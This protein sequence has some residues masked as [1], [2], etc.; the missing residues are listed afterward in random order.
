MVR[1]VRKD[2]SES[3]SESEDDETYVDTKYVFGA[4]DKDS[5]DFN[6]TGVGHQAMPSLP[7]RAKSTHIY[8]EPSEVQNCSSNS[9]SQIK[10][11]YTDQFLRSDQSKVSQ[12]FAKKVQTYLEQG[13]VTDA[14]E[15]STDESKLSASHLR[16]LK[17][18]ILAE[19]GPLQGQLTELMH[20][21]QFLKDVLA[22]PGAEPRKNVSRV[23]S[24]SSFNTLVALLSKAKQDMCTL[25]MQAVNSYNTMM[26]YGN[27]DPLAIKRPVPALPDIPIAVF[28]VRSG[29]KAILGGPVSLSVKVDVKKGVL[30][31]VKEGSQA[32]DQANT[33]PADKIAQVIKSTRNSRMLEI[34]IE[35]RRK[36]TFMF[37]DIRQRE[38]FCQLVQQL[39]KVHSM[40]MLV[41]NLSVF[42]GTWNMGNELPPQLGGLQPWIKSQ[43]V[44]KTRVHYLASESHDL[45]AIGTQEAKVSEK[46]WVNKLRRLLQNQFN[47]EFHLVDVCTLWQIRVVVFVKPEHKNRISMVQQ[48]VA[49]TGIANALGN[50]GAATISLNFDGTSLCFVCC[51]LAANRERL[52]RRNQNS[53]DILKVLANSIGSKAYSD[54]DITN[55]FNHFFV[56]G[57]LNY[58]VDG[59]IKEVLTLADDEK[60]ADMLKMDQLLD[61]INRKKAF[62]GFDEEMITFPPTYRYYKQASNSFNWKK[63]KS[64]G[65]KINAPSWCDRVM[66]KSLPNSPITNT[67]YGLVQEV[68]S[69][70]HKPVFASF[71]IQILPANIHRS[72]SSITTPIEIK[73][74]KV[75]C[76]LMMN[77]FG[78]RQTDYS[79]SI[80]GP[81]LE[82][83]CESHRATSTTVAEGKDSVEWDGTLVLRPTFSDSSYLETQHVLLAVKST[84]DGVV[85]GDTAVSLLPI[86]RS[87]GECKF[88]CVLT[89]LGGRAGSIKGVMKAILKGHASSAVPQNYPRS[90]KGLNANII[91][92]DVYASPLSGLSWDDDTTHNIPSDTTPR[93][94]SKPMS[95]VASEQN[96]GVTARGL[97][98]VPQTHVYDIPPVELPAKDGKQS[99]EYYNTKV[100]EYYNVEKMVPAFVSSTDGLTHTSCTESEDLYEEAESADVTMPSAAVRPE[101]ARPKVPVRMLD[102][103]T[104][105]ERINNVQGTSAVTSWL[106]K[107]SMPQY[108]NTFQQNNWTDMECIA[109]LTMTE[110]SSAGIKANHIFPILDAIAKI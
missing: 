55:Q 37:D 73:I 71:S 56:F 57:D 62:Y 14:I 13:L 84:V 17:E 7:A 51:H 58:R 4:V 101:T 29:G 95:L 64:S 47:I 32:L 28:V 74:S 19:T 49:R 65:V 60:Y 2:G 36:E 102:S 105:S 11:F 30:Y 103:L 72:V 25:E 110:L 61:T 67:S 99:S 70:D 93:I 22:Q 39:K 18:L 63:I 23:E 40:E 98:P 43:G 87:R 88:D 100:S 68:T 77:Q 89:N 83:P 97:L 109:Q 38:H 12:E 48:A 104:A 59:D 96:S 33:L 9:E 53:R 94:K 15:M 44:G 26:G 54:F 86:F 78:E 91:V 107:I 92:N 106:L 45:Y 20:K 82:A 35:G 66:W 108:V 69:S 5:P 80:M 1:G 85:V 75:S 41:D 46:D 8:A 90:K 3:D 52:A 81:C 6:K 79:V 16:I 50:K 31:I 21:L 24:E 27:V 76:L 10:D 34:L 42:C